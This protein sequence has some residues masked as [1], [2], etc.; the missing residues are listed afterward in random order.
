M[1]RVTLNN[2]RKGQLIENKVIICNIMVVDLDDRIVGCG[3]SELRRFKLYKICSYS[4]E[5]R[6]KVRMAW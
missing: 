6:I 2:T 4:S 3:G 5:Y 1:K